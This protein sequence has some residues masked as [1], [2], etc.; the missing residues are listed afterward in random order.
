VDGLVDKVD[1]ATNKVTVKPSQGGTPFMIDMP[2]AGQPVVTKAATVRADADDDRHNELEA[3]IRRGKAKEVARDEDT[4]E[5][6]APGADGQPRYTVRDRWQDVYID[7]V[8]PRPITQEDL[9][10]LVE[11]DDSVLR[12]FMPRDREI[13]ELKY[14]LSADGLTIGMSYETRLPYTARDRD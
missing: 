4:T 5:D 13:D 1:T 9:D 12:E 10:F 6:V 3:M 2:A 14:E 7:I 8:L 11:I